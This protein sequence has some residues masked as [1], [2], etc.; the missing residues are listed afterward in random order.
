MLAEI[1]IN[2]RQSFFKLETHVSLNNY[3]QEMEDKVME[4]DY[5]NLARNQLMHENIK[6]I[7]AEF[8]Q[9]KNI[10]PNYYSYLKHFRSNFAIKL[11][12]NEY[13]IVMAP[14]SDILISTILNRLTSYYKRMILFYPNYYSYEIYG[15]YNSLDVNRLNYLFLSDNEIFEILKERIKQTPGGLLVITNPDGFLGREFPKT[16]IKKILTLALEYN[17]LTIIDQAYSSFGEVNCI[18]LLDEYSNL[19]IINSFSKSFGMAGFRFA[20][21]FSSPKIVQIL[22]K[23]GV[24]LA[25]STHSLEYFNFLLSKKIDKIKEIIKDIKNQRDEFIYFV[26]S[27]C[28]NW[29][30]IKSHANFV[31]IDVRSSEKARML[32]DFLKTK[33]F[34]VRYLGKLTENLNTYVR[35]TV[36]SQPTMYRFNKL[37][38]SF[39]VDN[40]D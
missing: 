19:I 2:E 27:E 32:T 4:G 18:D 20:M 21:C 8:L 1:L 35:I 17:F 14:G 31:P 33:G 5:I 12:L 11:G 28:P 34:L 9:K 10:L 29:S 30:A 37:F 24:E 25:L 23:S 3:I 16:F 38:S 40:D 36:A 39:Y 15:S 22:Q 6:D 13:Q 26:K 7:Y